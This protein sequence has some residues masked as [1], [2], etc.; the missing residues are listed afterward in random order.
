LY[1]AD[2]QRSRK[3]CFR[4]FIAVAKKNLQYP[5]ATPLFV[6]PAKAGT[7]ESVIDEKKRKPG[8]RGIKPTTPRFW[9]PAFAGMTGK[10]LIS[11]KND[12]LILSG[13]RSIPSILFGTFSDG[14]LRSLG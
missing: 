9:V 5:K 4:N 8:E 7:Q 11:G 3:S 13:N 12:S 14:S 1:Q 10:G 2:A 6:I